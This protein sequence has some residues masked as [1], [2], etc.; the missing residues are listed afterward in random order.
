MKRFGWV[1]AVALPV[2]GQPV[3]AQII[4]REYTEQVGAKVEIAKGVS[5]TRKV[6]PI[7]DDEAPFFNFSKN[8]ETS[9][10]DADYAAT[11][12][13]QV[14]DREAAA[15]MIAESAARSLL[16]GKDVAAAGRRY[17]QAFL[18]GPHLSIVYHGF[19]V[20]VA[21]RF[22]DYK[23]AEELMRIAARMK[24]PDPSLNSDYGSLLLLRD[25]PR[26]AKPFLEKAVKDLP[27]SAQA[28]ANLALALYQTGDAKRACRLMADVHE[29]DLP[30]K[31][32][33]LRIFL[34]RAK[35]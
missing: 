5:V 7:P 11:V 35:C 9:P 16:V 17:N 23:F 3:G 10:S 26:E 31:G 15:R 21:E 6:Y 34:R 1:L 8:R 13:D 33:D 12:L 14:P 22:Q 4:A 25:R 30:G 20:L 18:I 28:R 27:N 2:I 29:A 32:R 24:S 19:A